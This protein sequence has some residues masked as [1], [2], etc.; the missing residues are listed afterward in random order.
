VGAAAKG[1][2]RAVERRRHLCPA[3][4]AS[5]DRLPGAPQAR[6]PDLRDDHGVSDRDPARLFLAVWPEPRLRAELAAYRDAWHWPAGAKPVADAALHVTLHFIGVFARAR[7]PVL[8]ASLAAVPVQ[9][10][11]VRP[12]GAEVWKGG[13]AV[14]RID[15]GRALQSLHE[16]L[17]TVLSAAGV[18]LDAR[19]FSPHVTLARKAA[20][21]EPP[22]APAAFDWRARGFALVESMP[23]GPA[24]YGVLHRFASS[25]P[26]PG[27]AAPG[28]TWS[29]IDSG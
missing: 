11:T 13:I 1:S 26:G 12:A 16:R 20:K 14:L 17:G 27:K 9:P 8:A 21:A 4:T 2:R 28:Q 7:I 23:G 19:P 3:A 5:E 10:V 24:H 6:W 25:G 18:A 22:S 15:A 29:D